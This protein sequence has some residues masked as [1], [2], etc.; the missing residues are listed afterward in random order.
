[1]DLQRRLTELLDGV[2]LRELFG[3]HQ[4]RVFETT[5]E[6]GDGRIV[7]KVIDAALVD[8][9]THAARVELVAALSATD[10]HVCRPLP[11]DGRLVTVIDLDGDRRGLVTCSEHAGGR[12]VD[13]GRPDDARLMGET[14]AALHRSL[15]SIGQTDLPP[16]AALRVVGIGG[17]PRQLLHGDFSASN[18]RE[19]D[20]MLRVF[21][22]DDCGYGPAAFDVADA[23]YMVR[24]D[25]M[26]GSASVSY[27]AFEGP[28]LAGYEAISGDAC[29]EDELAHLIRRRVAA[30]DAWLDDPPSA[31]AGIRTASPEWHRTL[32]TF[33][34]EHRARFGR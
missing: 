7:V 9:D 3:G 15:R 14:L 29:D 12:P 33:V 28:F 21:D 2:R 20:G 31:P 4:S 30:L 19:Q 17:G 23:L 27:R 5:G 16:V 13:V 26:M 24:F 6:W 1:M 22:F 10:P 18:L 25:D 32:R 11:I 34:T 8:R